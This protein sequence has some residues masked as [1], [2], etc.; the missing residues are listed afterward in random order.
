MQPP[1]SRVLEDAEAAV[2]SFVAAHPKSDVQTVRAGA[3]GGVNDLGPLLARLVK[4]G[5][6]VREAG[7]AGE[8]S[9]AGR[10][11][12]LYSAPPAARVQP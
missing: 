11:R 4:R 9:S 5:R 1:R 3:P 12:Y 8:G 6:L 2:I 10:P 7:L